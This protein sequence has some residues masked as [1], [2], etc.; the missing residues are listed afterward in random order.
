MK[1][2]QKNK[3]RISADL[4]SLQTPRGIK[5]C[6]GT[7]TSMEFHFTDACPRMHEFEDYWTTTIPPVHHPKSRV[8]VMDGRIDDQRSVTTLI[9]GGNYAKWFPEVDLGSV[10]SVIKTWNE[11]YPNVDGLKF[12]ITDGKLDAEFIEETPTTK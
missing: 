10:E 4:E 6:M 12:T 11:N 7:A 3:K 5:K 8:L 1:I 9:F 2:D